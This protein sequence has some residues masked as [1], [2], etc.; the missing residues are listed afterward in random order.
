MSQLRHLLLMLAP[1]ALTSAEITRYQTE[2]A[3]AQRDSKPGR[4]GAPHVA[5]RNR[6]GK[7]AW[8]K[9]RRA[10]GGCRRLTKRAMA[11]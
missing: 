9:L 8:K 11:R 6:S 10:R 2:A 3:A 7:T 1:M 5:Y 4:S